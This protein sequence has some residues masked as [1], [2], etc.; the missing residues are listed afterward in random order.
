[1]SKRF[2]YDVAL[3]FAGEDR[4]YVE[5]VAFVL[6]QLGVKVF[7]DN[8]HRVDLWGKDLYSHLDDV[9]RN[10]C[11]HCVIFISRFYSRKLWTNHERKSAQARAFRSRREY[12]LPARLDDTAI[13]G[14]RP[15]QGYFDLR[16]IS[17]KE[18]AQIITKKLG[19]WNE[20]EEMIEYLSDYL[21]DY[22]ITVNGASLHFESSV[23][24]FHDGSNFEAEFPIRLMLEMYRAGEMEKMFLLPAI[25]PH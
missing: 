10:K 1:M 23:E 17:P 12:L 19:K 13:P 3:S 7:Y 24:T 15:T 18:F 22:K 25:V 20:V 21:D 9:Y 2:Y 14:I 4:K 16:K 6:H 5:E 8:Y 11:R